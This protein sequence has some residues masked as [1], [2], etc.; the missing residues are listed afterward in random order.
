[1][2]VKLRNVFRSVTTTQAT[3]E[4]PSMG[5]VDDVDNETWISRCDS[6]FWHVVPVTMVGSFA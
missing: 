2:D 5:D 6:Q 3:M 1:M 4:T